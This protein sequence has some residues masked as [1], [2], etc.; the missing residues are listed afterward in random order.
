MRTSES[1]KSVFVLCISIFG[2]SCTLQH[3]H[4]VRSSTTFTLIDNDLQCMMI[5]GLCVAHLIRLISKKKVRGQ[6]LQAC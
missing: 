4:S 3:S 6:K 5:G 2:A 1:C